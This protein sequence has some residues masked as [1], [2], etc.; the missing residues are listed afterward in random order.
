MIYEAVTLFSCSTGSLLFYDPTFHKQNRLQSP[1]NI[2][3]FHNLTCN[4][5]VIESFVVTSHFKSK[6]LDT[7]VITFWF[8]S[9]HIFI[10]KL[11]LI[12]LATDL[13]KFF[14]LLPL[15]ISLYFQYKVAK[16][17]FRSSEQFCTSNIFSVYI[18]H[19]WN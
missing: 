3:L 15:M 7:L 19:Q 4:S 13:Q 17:I 5:H 11:V 16:E 9:K 2:N 8:I 12:I 1:E 6:C 18:Y 14:S 10:G